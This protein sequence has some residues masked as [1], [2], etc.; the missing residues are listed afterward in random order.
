MNNS[1]LPSGRALLF[2]L[3]DTVARNVELAHFKVYLGY[4]CFK[5]PD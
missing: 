1:A 2:L 5:I 3:V 4:F